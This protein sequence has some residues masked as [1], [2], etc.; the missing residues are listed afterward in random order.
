MPEKKKQQ[1]QQ[2]QQQQRQSKAIDNEKRGP[3]FM[4]KIQAGK[5]GLQNM[6]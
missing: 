1:Q 4:G 5:T 3:W 2:Q 6:S